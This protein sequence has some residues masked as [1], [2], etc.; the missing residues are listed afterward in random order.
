MR[1]SSKKICS[2]ES[3]NSLGQL[4]CR[5]FPTL[6]GQIPLLQYHFLVLLYVFYKLKLGTKDW[7]KCK[8]K[9][10]SKYTWQVR[11][12]TSRCNTPA[13]AFYQ[14]VPLAVMLSL[15]TFLRLWSLDLFVIKNSFPLTLANNIWDRR[16]YFNIGELF[17]SLQNQFT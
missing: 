6:F 10:F 8:L 2:I 16:Q 11:K 4:S 9:Y 14:W 17:G 13:S 3:F 5:M 1:T 15:A 7:I 12:C